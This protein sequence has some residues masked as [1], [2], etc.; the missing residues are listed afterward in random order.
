MIKFA[1]IK[2]AQVRKSHVESKGKEALQMFCVLYRKGST[3]SC[4]S[5]LCC[6]D[7][8]LRR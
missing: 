3:C 4:M 7:D 5:L 2:A 6:V 1:V 8:G